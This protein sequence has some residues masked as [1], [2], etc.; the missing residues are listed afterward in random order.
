[1]FAQ[2]SNVYEFK[3]E[4]GYDRSMQRGSQYRYIIYKCLVFNIKSHRFI[5]KFLKRNKII[6]NNICAI[7]TYTVP[8]KGYIIHHFL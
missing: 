2:I 8:C 5:R 3:C 6:R 1:M 7:L 4:I